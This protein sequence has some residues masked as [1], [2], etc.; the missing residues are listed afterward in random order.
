MYEN[1]SKFLEW[2]STNH[3]PASIAYRKPLERFVQVC[4]D[5]LL[6]EYVV[7]DIVRY[8]QWLSG[9]FSNESVR[10]ALT[11]LKHFFNFYK[12][13][14]IKCLS[15]MLIPMPRKLPAHSHRAI[16]E[17]EV[18]KMIAEIE[19]DS[20]ISSRNLLILLMLWDTGVRVTELCRMQIS[21]LDLQKK[22]AVIATEK[23]DIMRIILWS[24]STNTHLM[25]Y[26]EI[27][28][29]HFR[30]NVDD[31]VIPLFVASRSKRNIECLTRES[32]ER[33]VSYYARKAG[34]KKKTTPHTF[35]HGWAHAR[36]DL[37]A[38]LSFVQKGLG[39]T[40][41][42]STQVYQQFTDPEF[43]KAGKGYFASPYSQP[44]PFIRK[45]IVT[46]PANMNLV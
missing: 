24:E 6:E 3:V 39:H 25:K 34:I 42:V 17:D 16:E 15:S 9:Q 5:K 4:G 44:Q 19:G 30:N 13:Q 36:R 7:E 29:Q 12:S 22:Q 26:L 33:I 27:H 18:R 40:S 45:E 41:P 14:H 31:K 32:V 10:Y 37:G 38:P 1:I 8:N 35:R 21:D 23:R 28:K 46:I 43:V 11:I 2:K 20:F